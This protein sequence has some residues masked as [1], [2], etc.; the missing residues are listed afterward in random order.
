MTTMAGTLDDGTLAVLAE[1]HAQGESL[2]ALAAETGLSWQKL[3]G[4]VRGT[5]TPPPK[6]RKP[7]QVRRGVA[8]MVERYRPTAL[9]ALWGQERVVKVLRAFAASPSPSAFIFEGATGTGKTSAALA[10]AAALGCDL[11]QSDFGGVQ[12]IASGEQNADAVRDTFRSASLCPMYGS[13]WKVVIVNEA[14]RMGLPAETI[15][16]DRLEALPR[17]TVIVFTTNS[18]E[19]MSQRFIDRCTLLK[20]ESQAKALK[21]AMIEFAR[22]VWQA[23][24]GRELPGGR[25]AELVERSVVDGELS[26]RRVVQT[27]AMA[28]AEAGE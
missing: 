28:I 14:D 17:R 12:T 8:S 24:T 23:E 13:G 18:L 25:A 6:V 21:P 1:R 22:A 19:R 16:L 20:F 7:L 5:G 4:L 9:D 26:F 10:L 2:K 27:V 11:E 3:W 15:W